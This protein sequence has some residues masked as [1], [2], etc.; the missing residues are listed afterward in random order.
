M[1]GMSWWL[2]EQWGCSPSAGG[3]DG[4]FGDSGDTQEGV[5]VALEAERT[6]QGYVTVV[7]GQ[8]GFNPSSGGCDSGFGD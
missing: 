1:G 2:C 6:Q 5:M 8:E 3:C 4:V 7:W